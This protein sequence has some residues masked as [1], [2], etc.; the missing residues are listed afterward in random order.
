MGNKIAAKITLFCEK[1]KEV[2][3]KILFSILKV[4]DWIKEQKKTRLQQ[5]DNNNTNPPKG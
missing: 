5:K 1:I 3:K 2:L 4:K